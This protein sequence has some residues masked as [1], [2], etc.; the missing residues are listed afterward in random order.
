M[1]GTFV[2]RTFICFASHELTDQ[3][4]VCCIVVLG[5]LIESELV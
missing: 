4:L 5:S 3:F 2:G 1:A